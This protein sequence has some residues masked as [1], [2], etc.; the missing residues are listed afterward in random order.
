MVM[1]STLMCTKNDHLFGCSHG[2]VGI[3]GGLTSPFNTFCFS[4]FG[5][6]FLVWMTPSFC[7]FGIYIFSK[8][9]LIFSTSFRFVMSARDCMF[10]ICPI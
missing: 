7:G 1:I 8:K 2:W 10:A 9:N 6:D 4:F 5:A 3:G